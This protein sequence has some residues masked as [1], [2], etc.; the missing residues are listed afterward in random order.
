MVSIDPKR[1]LIRFGVYPGV[2]NMNIIPA[3]IPNAHSTPMAESSRTLPVA[4]KR[5]SPK[6]EATEKSNAPKSGS[7]P[8]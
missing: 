8:R 7:N 6:A 5:S 3:A 4:M 1:K 2:R